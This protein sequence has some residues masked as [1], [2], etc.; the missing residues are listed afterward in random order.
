VGIALT[1]AQWSF[2]PEVKAHLVEL[3]A[4]GAAFIQASAKQGGYRCDG[5][6]FQF[7]IDV[8]VTQCIAVVEVGIE[9]EM[10]PMGDLKLGIGGELGFSRGAESMDLVHCLCLGE[11]HRG[12]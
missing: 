1:P 8:A 6:Q 3:A 10:K 7:E 4:T 2:I 11:R 5:L 12:F 9:D